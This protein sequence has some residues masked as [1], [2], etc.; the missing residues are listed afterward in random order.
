M[1]TLDRLIEET[2]A[3]ALVATMRANGSALAS[4]LKT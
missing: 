4:M 3:K 1:R 2:G